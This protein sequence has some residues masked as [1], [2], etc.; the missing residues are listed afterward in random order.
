MEKRNINDKDS[1][2]NNNNNII[3]IKN[4]LCTFIIICPILDSAS[5]LFRNIF[6]TKI[7]PSTFIRALVPIV[8]ILYLFF[9][10]GEKFKKNMV[11]IGS[12][13][14]L[15][16]I[17]HLIVFKSTI[18]K[19]SYGNVLHE[20]Q[21]IMNY[22]FMIINLI[23]FLYIFT[24]E[25]NDKKGNEKLAKSLLISNVIY[26]LLIFIAIIT[27]TSSR[28]YIEGMGYKGWF[29]SGNSIGSIL[30]LSLFVTIGFIKDKKYRYIAIPTIVLEGI[31]LTMLLGTRVGL[32]G[33]ILVIMTYVVVELIFSIIHKKKNSKRILVGGIVTIIVILSVIIT[34]GSTTV[35]R[36]KHLHDIEKN[37]YDEEKQEESH[38]TGSLLKI[39]EKID[40]NILEEN[41]MTE[42][43]KKSVIDL[44]NICNKYKIK[45]NDQRN[46][47]LIYNIALIKNQ[48]NPIYILFGNGYVTNFR[49]LILEMEIPAFLLNFGIYGFILYFVPFLIIWI[50]GLYNGMK[51]IKKIDSQY[52]MLEIGT[53]FVFLLSFFAGYTFFNSSNMIIIVV[54]NTML[55]N[56]T[57]K[58][59]LEE[60][61]KGN[62]G[63]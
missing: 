37:I 54:L 41:F 36:R 1:K 55:L 50:Y 14:L 15:Y 42:A 57:Y 10:K 60:N 20:A 24:K 39:K 22:T 33:F 61:K 48:K 34:L 25:K 46:Q 44:Y 30:I 16:G 19:S 27:K 2:I 45:N 29:E 38:I 47:Q 63:K 6:N 8:L 31:F 58:L 59:K 52:V 53:G 56:K 40:N 13:Y 43:E 35:Q 51:N 5:F 62:R 17:I 28:T 4:I 9:K 32:L 7:S 11:L 26:I 18:T 21:Y 49:E 23:S 3:N 12:T